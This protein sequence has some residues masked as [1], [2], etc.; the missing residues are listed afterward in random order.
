MTQN[1]ACSG[2]ALSDDAQPVFAEPWMAQAFA[3]TLALHQR[4]LFSWPEW[5]EALSAQIAADTALRS[6]PGAC[7]DT[8]KHYYQHWLAALEQLVASKG[9]ASAAE[10]QRHAQAWA[11]AAERTPHG[12][13]LALLP[14]DFAA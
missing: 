11:S 4:G 8:G 3:L 2:Q 9:A 13:P 5:A 12:Q 10:L 6:A 14:G 7:T 1:P